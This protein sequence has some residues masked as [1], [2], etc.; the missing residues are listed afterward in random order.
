[1]DSE[2]YENLLKLKYYDGKVE[3]LGLTMTIAEN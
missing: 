2:Q 1:L 3:D